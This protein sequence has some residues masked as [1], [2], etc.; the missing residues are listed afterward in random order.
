MPDVV[1]FDRINKIDLFYHD[2]R[3]YFNLP[4]LHHV[5]LINNFVALKT[6]S[7]NFHR[8]FDL[9]IVNFLSNN[10]SILSSLTSLSMLV[11]YDIVIHKRD[12][13]F[14]QSICQIIA[15]TVPILSIVD[16]SIRFRKSIGV[17]RN[18]IS[19]IMSLR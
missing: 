5:T 9:H 2:W 10:W 14:D 7:I 8:I 4:A 3:S 16:C 13:A 12:V 19:M 6:F 18:Y 15:Q 1:R 17:A 11:S